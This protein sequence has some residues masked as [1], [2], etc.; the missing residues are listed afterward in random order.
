MK[1]KIF[2]FQILIIINILF[3]N[4]NC[5][6]QKQKNNK[7]NNNKI[8]SNDNDREIKIIIKYT[9]NSKLVINHFNQLK[10]SIEAENSKFVVIG[11]DYKLEGIRKKLS[12][13]IISLQLLLSS[14]VACSDSVIYITRKFIPRSFFN[15]TYKH[16][17][18]KIVSI[19]LIG[20]FINNI[21]NYIHPFEIFCDGKLIWSGLKHNGRLIRPRELLKIIEKD[22][23]NN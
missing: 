6:Y 3:N 20:N 9:K 14:I 17:L 19:F 2:I 22:I 21:I 1:K 10:E 5:L 12:Y 16:K 13:I 11:E 8:Y 23:L 15:W 18:I 4:I 7:I